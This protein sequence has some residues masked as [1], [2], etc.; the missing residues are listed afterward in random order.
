[1]LML[2]SEGRNGYDGLKEPIDGIMGLCMGGPSILYP[3][4]FNCDESS[5]GPM[6]IKYLNA[7]DPSKQKVFSFYLNGVDKESFIDFSGY[8][9]ERIRD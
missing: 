1:M 3:C 4:Y 8:N 9:V 7:E 5:K 6:F 2:T